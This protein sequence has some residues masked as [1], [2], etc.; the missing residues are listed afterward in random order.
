MYKFSP[1]DHKYFYNDMEI[2]SVTSVLPYNF[3]GNENEYNKVRGQY[4]H[5]MIYLHNTK[6]LDEETLDPIL[7]PYLE[8]YKK[9]ISDIKLSI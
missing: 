6:I 3:F 8:G 9:F 7:K 1:A 5:K 2:P 4:V